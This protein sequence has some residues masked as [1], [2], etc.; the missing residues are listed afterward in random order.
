MEDKQLADKIKNHIEQ[1]NCLISEAAVVGIKIILD[2]TDVTSIDDQVTEHL[3]FNVRCF[4][5]F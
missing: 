5:E 4:K 3:R 2:P 1:L